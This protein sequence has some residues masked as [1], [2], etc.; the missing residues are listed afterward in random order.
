MILRRRGH[1]G[2]QPGRPRLRLAVQVD[3]WDRLVVLTIDPRDVFG[4][5][6]TGAEEEATMVAAVQ[7]VV[8]GLRLPFD[9]GV[10]VLAVLA[11]QP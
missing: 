10:P 6:P 3:A 11:P 4:V 2:A 9:Q 7:P 5:Y 1:P 8:V